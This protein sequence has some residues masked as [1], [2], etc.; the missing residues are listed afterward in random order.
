MFA[1]IEYLLC[2]LPVLATS[3][4][5]GRDIFFDNECA[6]IV[7]DTPE[8]V[9]SGLSVLLSRQLDPD[10]VRRKTLRRIEEHRSTLVH[11]VCR[12]FQMEG[13][14]IDEREAS[15]RLFPNQIYKLRP[16]HHVLS[17]R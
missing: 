7:D 17:H 6:E 14:H 9:K 11:L 3:S 1:S 5:G 10:Y 4:F 15:S 13:M 16:L 8:A 12:L 2:G